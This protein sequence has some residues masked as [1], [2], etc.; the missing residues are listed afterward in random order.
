MDIGPEGSEQHILTSF[1][2]DLEKI[3]DPSFST[4]GHGTSPESAPKILKKA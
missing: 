1:K 2:A 3:Y 4:L